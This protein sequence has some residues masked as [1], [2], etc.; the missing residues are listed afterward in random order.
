MIRLMATNGMLA[1]GLSLLEA[2]GG[3]PNGVGVSQVAREVGLPVSTAHRLLATMV[4]LG[5]VHFDAEHRRYY[6]GLKVFELSHQVSLARR[7]SEV[8]LPVM[9]RAAGI[10]RESVSLAVREGKELV[11][12]EWAE[13]RNRIQVSGDIG[14]RGPLY[15]TSQGKILLALLPEIE[16]DEIIGEIRLEPRGPNTITDPAELRREL[17]RTRER[18]YAVADEEN[19]EE[20]RAIA[21]PVTNI[22]GEPI[23]ALSVVAPTFRVPQE[24]LEK[25]VPLLQEAAREIGLQLQRGAN[26]LV[27]V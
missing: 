3:H 16:R 27:R 10:T 4:T 7:L 6:L 26:S 15:S 17:E 19:E 8:A 18:G 24:D 11:Y 13:G 5:F 22:R 12:I 20:I 21:V 23:A 9:K 2:L 14:T 1:K 25:F